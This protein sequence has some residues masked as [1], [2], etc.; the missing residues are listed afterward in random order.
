M[1]T[2]SNISV[3]GSKNCEANITLGLGPHLVAMKLNL[4]QVSRVTHGHIVASWV[5]RP[6]TVLNGVQ[7]SQWYLKKIYP[8]HPFARLIYVYLRKIIR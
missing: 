5:E 7:C 1:G 6:V 4:Y 8:S 2:T 3:G